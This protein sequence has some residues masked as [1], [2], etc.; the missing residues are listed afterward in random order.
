MT[1]ES[2]PGMWETLNSFLSNEGKERG[3]GGRWEGSVRERGR[4]SKK[5]PS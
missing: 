2:L 1:E 5:G 4:N 3:E